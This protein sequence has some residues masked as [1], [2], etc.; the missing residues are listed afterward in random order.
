MSNTNAETIRD[1]LISLGFDIDNASEQKFNSMVAGVTANVLKLGAAVEGAAL[2]VV[3]FTAQV[4]NGLDKLYWQAQRTGGAV[5]QIKSLGY[6]VSQAGGTVEGLNSSLEGVAKFLRNNPGGEGFLRNMGIQTRDANGKLRD[7]ASLVAL[8]GERLSALPTYRANQYASILGIDENTLMAMRRGIGGYASDYHRIIKTLGYNP[9]VASQHANA[10]MTQMYQLKLV[11]G[12]AKEKVGGELARVLTPSVEKFTKYILANWPAIEKIIMSVVKAILTMSEILGQL[13]FRGAKGIQDL[14]GWWKQ[15]DDGSQNLIKAFGLIA[16]A[17]WAL[18]LKFLASPIGIVMSLLAALFLLY[19]DY[20]TWKEKGNSFFDWSEWNSS[21]EY[22]L[23]KL[24][25]F[26]EWF[27]NSPIGQWFKDTN[28]EVDLLQAAFAGLATYLAVSWVGKILGA[29]GKI[30]SSLKWLGKL[31]AV[32]MVID[33]YGRL[34]DIQKEAK[35]NGVDV[36]THLYNK[37]KEN[38]KNA[39]AFLTWDD[40]RNWATG[41]KE[42]KT[43]N[44]VTQDTLD[45]P[46]GDPK[47]DALKAKTRRGEMTLDEL[48]SIISGT[49]QKG[50][51]LLESMAGYFSMLEKKYGLNPGLLY[52]IAMTESSGDPNAIG[53]QTR[54]GKAKGMFQFMPDTAAQYG[55]KGDDIFDPYKAAEAAARYLSYLLKLHNGDIDKMLASYNWGETR[56]LK[57]GISNLP[58]ETKNYLPRVK[59]HMANAPKASPQNSNFDPRMFDN[60]LANISNMVGSIDPRIIDNAM[61]NI[62][63]MV[64]S[65]GPRIINNAQANIDNMMSQ[66][67]PYT[68][69]LLLA[70]TGSA[71]NQTTISPTYNVNVSGV[72]S[73]REAAVLTSEAVQRTNAILVR[74][75][76]TKVS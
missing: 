69:Q 63:N 11:M 30:G 52:G 14:I 61:V 51:P 49:P 53:K 73:P 27:K 74:S 76:Q 56:V 1:F 25:E 50:K 36:G 23:K 40:I 17:W 34:G 43:G 9:E 4:A 60:A 19:D 67:V 62:S 26:K 45:I 65:I 6:A 59:S 15:L 28:S 8:V 22:I 12:S 39:E 75:L 41:S 42:V 64:G 68:A 54:F 66:S 13:V 44:H 71:S 5:E 29:F 16:A 57:K 33:S 24:D 18:N 35:E 7:T 37:I 46:T 58:K 21:L 55:L 20:Q 31:A 47:I 2:A 10:F 72:E 32:A 70:G 3:G 48:N 38:E